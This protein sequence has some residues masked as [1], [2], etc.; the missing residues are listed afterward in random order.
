MPFRVP[1]AAT[2][3]QRSPLQ[4][5]LGSV[6]AAVHAHAPTAV[7]I[8]INLHVSSLHF[9]KIMT[10]FPLPLAHD[11]SNSM[12][13]LSYTVPGVDL[14]LLSTALRLRYATQVLTF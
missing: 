10:T 12:Q 11:G 7:A 9:G 8:P 13:C 14:P 4:P 5:Y 6:S 2:P 3:A 1:H